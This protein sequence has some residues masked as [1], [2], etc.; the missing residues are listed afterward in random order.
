MWRDAF[1]DYHPAVVFMFFIGAIILSILI[2]NIAI[3]ALGLIVATIYYL[4]LVR[5]KG[6]KTLVGLFAFAV[7]IALVNPLF[8]T[9]GSTT[10]FFL[11]NSRPFTLESLIYGIS[12]AMMFASVL[13]WFLSFNKVFSSEKIEYLFG[14]F[15]PKLTLVFMMVMNFFPRFSRKS[16]EL[17]QAREGIGQTITNGRTRIN[18]VKIL[19]SSFV[20]WALEGS[21]I[22]ANSM[23][24]RGYG[25]RKR[26]SY[27]RIRIAAR[28]I[29]LIVYLVA[30]FGIAVFGIAFSDAVNPQYFPTI[31]YPAITFKGILSSIAFVLLL[32]IPLFIDAGEALRWSISRSR[33]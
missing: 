22:T 1:S 29:I 13:L 7:I 11:W 17:I 25:T 9:Q 12:S 15:A 31:V 3:Q 24:S 21:I 20:G 32:A 16:S 4:M 5:G 2:S 26:T 18:V 14:R 23:V 30:L 28:D 19:L 8:N 6:A 27:I 33:I 10:L